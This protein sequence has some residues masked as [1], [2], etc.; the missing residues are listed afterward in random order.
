[1]QHWLGSDIIYQAQGEGDLGSRMAR[2]LSVAFQDG[3]ER[4]VIIGTDCPG[5]NAQLLKKHFTSYTLII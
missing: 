2:S 5:L 4:V 3:I 1:M